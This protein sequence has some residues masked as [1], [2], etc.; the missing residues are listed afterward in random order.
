MPAGP[1]AKESPGFFDLMAFSSEVLK[2][3]ALWFTA[4]SWTQKLNS[5]KF[6]QWRIR[7]RMWRNMYQCRRSFSHKVTT[8]RFCPQ[9]PTLTPGAGSK[10]AVYIYPSPEVSAMNFF[11]AFE[12]LRSAAP[13]CIMYINPTNRMRRQ[14]E[15]RRR[16]ASVQRSIPEVGRSIYDSDE[17]DLLTEA[18]LRLGPNNL[19]VKFRAGLRRSR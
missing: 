15:A 1:E 16:E 11:L 6:D 10:T 17:V 14:D 3:F 9:H 18:S 5:D 13:A 2:F 8:R 19:L 4:D 7:R 12:A